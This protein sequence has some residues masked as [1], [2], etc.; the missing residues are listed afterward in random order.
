[1][2]ELMKSPLTKI[3]MYTANGNT[4]QAHQLEYVLPGVILPSNSVVCH[5]SSDALKLSWQN[6]PSPFK[7][8][9]TWFVTSGK[10]HLSLKV[11]GLYCACMDRM[12]VQLGC[13]CLMFHGINC[14]I[15]SPIC[16]GG[17][18][19]P[20]GLLWQTH[21]EH[22]EM[23]FI[24]G[25]SCGLLCWT[26]PCQQHCCKLRFSES[27]RNICFQSSLPWTQASRTTMLVQSVVDSPMSRVGSFVMI[28][29]ISW[30]NQVDQDLAFVDRGL[31]SICGLDVWR[32]KTWTGP[33]DW[34]PHMHLVGHQ[35]FHSI[36]SSKSIPQDV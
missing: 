4:I 1:M 12:K 31:A 15:L 2:Y 3:T 5:G 26:C 35:P 32:A 36:R 24:L 25:R 16:P 22:A 9:V 19:S 11:C 18:R 29:L 17:H 7:T 33:G 30:C 20:P 34:V 13:S 27:S 23:P 28:H 21:N 14:G 6:C 10:H 8:N